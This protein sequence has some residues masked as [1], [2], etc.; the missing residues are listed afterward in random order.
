MEEP[1]H[2]KVPQQKLRMS[3]KLQNNQET[4]KDNFSKIYKMGEKECDI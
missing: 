4:F 3:P 2:V 1:F